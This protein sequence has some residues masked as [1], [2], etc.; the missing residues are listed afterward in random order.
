MVETR[1]AKD[2]IALAYL[3]RSG[4]LRNLG[5]LSS[6]NLYNRAYAGTKLLIED[7]IE[8]VIRS[9]VYLAH[10]P[11]SQSSLS[12]QAKL[13]FFHDAR[14]TFGRSAL[15]LQGG[16]M[17]GLVHIG[18]VKA[19]LAQRLLPR[20]ICGMGVGALIATLVC[21][22][23]NDELPELLKPSGL[24]LSAFSRKKQQG[25][26]RRKLRRF[27]RHGHLMDVKVIEELVR[28]NVGDLTFEEAYQ[29]TNRVLN[30]IIAPSGLFASRSPQLLNYLAA[31]NVLIRSAACV[32][33]AS[34]FPY[35]YQDL[36]LLAKNENGAIV[37]WDGSSQPQRDRRTVETTSDGD[38]P[39]NRI[40]QLFNC[41]HFIVSQARPYIAP[42]ISSPLRRH[43]Q[44]G[45]YLKLL[46]LVGD[47]IN[48]RMHQLDFLGLLPLPLRRFVVDEKVPGAEIT[49]VP[50][51]R[52]R[53]FEE[54]LKNPTNDSLEYWVRKGEQ[55]IW[56]ALTLIIA[57]CRIELTLD[58][59]I[60]ASN[61][62]T[63][64]NDLVYEE[65]R[66]PSTNGDDQAS[67]KQLTEK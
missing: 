19:L 2:A 59:R 14:Q 67:V 34:S 32:S 33:N 8:E 60:V 48:H 20:I 35:L 53:D 25:Q 21:G 58:Q 28:H 30:I 47:E 64:F 63:C 49:L 46:T 1:E 3:L 17:F 37:P 40:V 55:I 24:N 22:H 16:A 61:F 43:R 23:T 27:L 39:Y 12:L 65:I 66:Y 7:Y 10:L 6:R 36:Q 13:D 11:P 5:N 41:N 31:P 26:V 44:R 42:F 51:L 54:L 18:V 57:R 45:L 38:M 56:P 52:L 4:L 29:K 9:L 15:V 62:V 50:E